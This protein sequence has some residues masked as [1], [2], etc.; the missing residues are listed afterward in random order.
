MGSKSESK[1]PEVTEKSTKKELLDA[2]EH[3]KKMHES[4]MSSELN[5]E[6]VKEEKRKDEVVKTAEVEVS[7][8]IDSKVKDLQLAFAK[9]LA[10]L[11]E[12]LKIEGEKYSELKEAVAFKEAELKAIY[13]IEQ[14]ASTLAALIE[15]QRRKEEDFNAE[16]SRRRQETEKDLEETEAKLQGEIDATRAS[17]EQQ[18]REHDAALKE[19]KASE[20]KER[21]R[22]KEDFEYNFQRE[23]QQRKDKLADELSKSEKEMSQRKESFERQAAEKD[24]ELKAREEKVAQREN[25]VD[26]LQKQVDAFPAELDAKVKQA[27]GDITAKLTT[28]S[29]SSEK[30]LRAQLAGEKNVLMAK[31][32]ALES[33]VKSHEKQ[34][35]TLYAK[36]EAAYGNVQDIAVK[37]VDSSAK[38]MKNI[39]VQSPSMGKDDGKSRDRD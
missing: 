29:E 31:I 5:P 39:T 23:C 21:A 37:A 20:E 35:S 36:L 11:G 3:L 34:N 19:Q 14:N 33:V 8:S 32:E 22:R 12:K 38:Q 15:A 2:I 9:A 18:K 6:K 30:L 16:M 27:V 17:W 25:L 24:A 7:G 13:D 28:Q 10:E 4:R 1:M 26:A